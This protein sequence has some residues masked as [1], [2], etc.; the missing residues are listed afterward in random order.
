M[1]WILKKK[2]IV[3]Y[4]VKPV[5]KI[6]LLHIGIPSF[7]MKKV[8]NVKINIIKYLYGDVND[9]G[10][11]TFCQQRKVCKNF[12]KIMIMNRKTVNFKRFNA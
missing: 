11:T 9:M 1:A 8:I 4:K 3:F 2:N 10:M 6:R 12:Q 7:I 5:K